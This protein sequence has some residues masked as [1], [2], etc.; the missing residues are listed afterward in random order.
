MDSMKFDQQNHTLQ[1]ADKVSRGRMHDNPQA[2]NSPK[3]RSEYFQ[4]RHAAQLERER[5]GGGITAEGYASGDTL[6][7]HGTGPL[8]LRKQMEAA[9][10]A[11]ADSAK[12]AKVEP[13]D[14]TRY[15]E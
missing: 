2:M 4:L 10:Q 15:L 6:I 14:T 8:A 12:K 7:G 3:T 9:R 11:T 1:Q 5:G 13:P